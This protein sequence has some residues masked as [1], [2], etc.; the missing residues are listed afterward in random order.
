MENKVIIRKA[1][2]NDL[3][4]IL[5][6]YEIARNYMK[7]NGNSTQWKNNYPPKELLVEDIK[8]GILFVIEENEVVH[9]VFTFILGE[10]PTYLN[11]KD[12]AWLNDSP[13]GTI[14]RIASDGKIKH[15]LLRA[16]N[17][18][19]TKINH[20][21]IDTHLDNKIMNESLLKYGFRKTGTIICSDGT[22]RVAYEYF[23]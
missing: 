8:E 3:P 1:T 9:A 14:H 4:K 11:I 2:L 21:R 10:D 7:E 13:Y 15:S 18:G 12:G 6:I 17:F 5:E 20:I 22:P 16:I 23:K 19:L